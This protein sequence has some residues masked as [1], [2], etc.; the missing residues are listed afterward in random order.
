MREITD[1]AI[2]PGL[3][4]PANEDRHHRSSALGVQ[5][6]QQHP[7]VID[8]RVKSRVKQ[9]Q[10]AFRPKRAHMRHG[11]GVRFKFMSVADLKFQPVH[12][13]V[14]EPFT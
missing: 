6:I 3:A 12:R 10:I 7:G 14:A 13:I 1:T 4:L 2:K 5:V 8:D 9:R 11:N